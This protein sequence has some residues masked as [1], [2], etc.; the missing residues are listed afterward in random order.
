MLEV[1]AELRTLP[2]MNRLGRTSVSIS[3]P[4]NLRRRPAP[5]Q[6][7]AHPLRAA[8][9]GAIAAAA[10]LLISYYGSRNGWS[11]VWP[12]P[13]KIFRNDTVAQAAPGTEATTTLSVSNFIDP[14]QSQ[15]VDN[16]EQSLQPSLPKE[17]KQELSGVREQSYGN[18]KPFSPS[19]RSKDDRK[20]KP[21]QRSP[22]GTSP[23]GNKEETQALENALPGK[24]LY[25]TLS[26]PASNTDRLF[27]D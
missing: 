20:K 10:L 14:A 15:T 13:V 12:N 23:L 27:D 1:I 9:I 2:M 16:P 7:K 26:D 18:A 22:N 19:S 21:G 8:S 24:V 6:P 3:R 5:P 11:I 25:K 4:V 17:K